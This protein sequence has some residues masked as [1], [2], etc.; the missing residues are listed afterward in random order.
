MRA[1][2]VGA[3]F[4]T[5]H[6][7]GKFNVQVVPGTYR[8]GFESYDFDLDD[9]A[10]EFLRN[11]KSFLDSGDDIVVPEPDSVVTGIDADLVPASHI[12]GTITGNFGHPVVE[13]SV[14]AFGYNAETDEWV[15]I[16]PTE[17]PTETDS[18]G[19]YFIKSLPQGTYQSGS[20]TRSNVI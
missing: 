5:T 8:L 2:W 6:A 11:D 7:S 20:P 4:D 16:R 18:A 13:V 17:P 3:G 9:Y 19:N 1:Q 10:D 15:E 14:A 12:A